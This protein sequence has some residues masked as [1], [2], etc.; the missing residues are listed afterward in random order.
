MSPEQAG[1]DLE[2]LGPRSDVYGL[3][4][5][6]YCLLTG[7]PPFEG[8][9]IGEVLRRVQ[10]GEF[11]PPRQLDPSL[12]K[13]LEAVCLKAMA[14]KPEDR[15]AVAEAL[16]EDI[17]RWMADEPVSAWREPLSRRVRRWANRN[18]TVVAS[19]AVALIAGVVG[20][21]AVLAVQTQA[22]ADIAAALA[23]RRDANG[24]LAAANDELARSRAAVQ[25]GTTWRSRRS[26]RSTPASARTSCSSRTS[27]RSCA[28]G[29]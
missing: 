3:G 18:R 21:S 26:R 8:E 1:G 4:A 11:P 20:L 27:S 16:A 29:C 12:D 24:A 10:A 2:R 25:R 13:A 6:L 19:A 14:T 17:E 22:K 7:R 5:T 9:D 28:T 15:Y 23:A